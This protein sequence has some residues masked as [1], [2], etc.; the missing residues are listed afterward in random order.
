MLFLGLTH[1]QNGKIL[2]KRLVEL[3]DTPIWSSISSK[4][5]LN[6]EFAHLNRLNFYLISYQ[7]DAH[8]VRGIVVEPKQDG[9]YPVIIFNRGGNRDFARLTVATMIMYV[10]RLADAGFVIVGSNYRD[11][12]EFGGADIN[13]VLYLTE[14]VKDLEKADPEN[15]GMFG[16][17]RGG[18]M[19]YLALQKSDQI[20]TAIIGNGPTDL[21]GL[22]ADRPEM[23][24]DVIAECVPN[25]WENKDAE[26]KKRSSIYWTE[27]LDKNASL[28]ILCGT[29][30]E[31]VNP[32]QADRIAEKLEAI[33]YNFTLQKYDTDHQFSTM[34]KELDAL[35][36]DWFVS[37]L[38]VDQH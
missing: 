22:I 8:V 21:F 16:W 17:S 24:T 7:S 32:N 15:I 1:A 20:R 29:R 14:T 38:K 19:T 13:D 9:K 6:D 10:S 18:M 3:S 27:E 31:S 23:E 2:S 26:L 35:V 28:L 37:H 36:L 34:K 33:N 30:D 12:D 5:Q 11:Q 25:Y 4:N